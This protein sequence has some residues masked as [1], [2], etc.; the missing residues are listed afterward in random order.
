MYVDPTACAA[1]VRETAARVFE[2]QPVSVVAGTA[3]QRDDIVILRDGEIVASSSVDE[4]LRSV[5]LINSDV[6]LTGTQN[7]G[8]VVFPDVLKAL[9]GT[10]LRL[11]GYPDSDSEKLLLIAASRGIER[12]AYET[13]E[14]TLRV[15]FQR[16]SRLVDEPGTYS[17][18]EQLCETGLDVHAYGIEDTRPPAELDVT[19]HAGTSEFHRRCWF[20]VFT[21]SSSGRRP[22]ALLATEREHNCWK[23]F[24]TFQPAPVESIRGLVSAYG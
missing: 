7:L 4:L 16:L 15:G 1:P 11:R 24:W 21:P 3:D 9:E 14:G 17:V 18:Y 6:Y 10:P 20:V 22:A 5:L 19:V 13:G 12:L 23:G 2:N 8:D